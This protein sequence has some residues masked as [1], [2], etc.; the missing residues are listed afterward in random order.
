VYDL[1]VTVDEVQGFCDLPMEEGD[2][3]WVKGGRII[4]PPGQG[5]CLWALQS[6]MPFFPAKQR[7]IEEENDWIPD[8]KRLICPDPNGGVV[9]KIERLDP[10]TGEPLEEKGG[11]DP[12]PRILVDPDK[13][14]GCRACETVCSLA[15]GDSFG[16][17]SSRIR[18]EKDEPAGVDRPLVCRQ[19]GDAP[20]VKVCPTGALGRD[21]ETGAVTV[22]EEKCVQCGKC[23]QA[24]PF[25]GIFLPSADEAPL[26][27][28]LC[29]GE[30]R[31]VK[32]CPTEAL[33]FGNA[34]SIGE[35]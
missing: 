15:H 10:Q 26:V 1:K 16:A 34:G 13:C 17:G 9:F 7:V 21:P 20:C 27:C 6:M 35:S 5:V 12:P 25:E 29:G 33:K 19:C 30:P 32:R 24:C 31:C 8:T 11:K 4:T 22:A 14:S 3:F 28:D 18:V 23:V 2:H